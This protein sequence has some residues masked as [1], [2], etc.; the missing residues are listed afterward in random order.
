[1]GDDAE[2][3]VAANVGARREPVALKFARR[4]AGGRVA[5]EQDETAASVEQGGD[6]ITRESDDN[7]CRITGGRAIA[8]KRGAS[9]ATRSCTY[10]RDL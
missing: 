6:G 5:T 1:M 10:C 9:A 2:D 3:V 8:G 7:G 4:N